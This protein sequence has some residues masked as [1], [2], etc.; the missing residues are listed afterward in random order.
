MLLR[1]S[2]P[3]LSHTHTRT[4]NLPHTHTTHNQF[5]LPHTHTHP[6]IEQIQRMNNLWNTDSL[7][8]RPVLKIPVPS[9]SND[10]SRSESPQMSSQRRLSS[11]QLSTLSVEGGH[12]KNLSSSNLNGHIL[13]EKEEEVRSKNSSFGQNHSDSGEGVK[14][15][16]GI[17]SSADEQLIMARQFAEKLALRW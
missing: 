5:P 13:E 14:S 1:L 6:Q 8:I 2:L 3:P 7:H 11:E 10:S 4:T 16:A 17:L 12:Q 15:I 9:Y